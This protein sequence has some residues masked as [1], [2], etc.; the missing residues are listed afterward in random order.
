MKLNPYLTVILA[1]TIGGSNGVF[2]KLLSLPSTSIT[3]FRVFIPVAILL[4]YFGWK[5][6]KLFQGN[7]KI[8]LVAS[9]LNAA[10]MFF[11]IF[12]YLHTSIGNAVIF[13]FTWPIFATIFGAIFFRNSGYVFK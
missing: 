13:L 10:R 3:F 5:K 4:V 7:Y 6:I 2:I 9:G 8:M 1:A 12:A 11:F